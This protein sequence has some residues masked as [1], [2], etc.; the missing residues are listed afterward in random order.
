MRLW[1]LCVLGVV[2]TISANLA[3]AESVD[4][5]SGRVDSSLTVELQGN[6]TP[7]AR[8]ES[9]RGPVEASR[10]LHVTILFLP[11]AAQQQALSK[12][13]A[14][15]QN[16]KSAN[17]HKWLTSPEYGARFGL[18]L[19]DVQKISAWLVAQGFKVTYVAN[20]RDFLSF[21]GTAAQVAAVFKTEIHYF[22]VNGRRHF[23]NTTP[24]S[25]PAS[26]EGIVGG[27]RGL[28]DFF[29]RPMLKAHPDYTVSGVSGHFL[30]PGDIATIYDINPLYQASIDGTGENV[31]I[32]G[33]SDVYLAD[34]NYFRAAFNLTQLSGC[35][36]NSSGVI[37]AGAC[38]GGN[39][40]Q[41]WPNSADPGVQATS[42]DLGESDL[43]I[44]WMNA[45]ARGAQI[46]FV[47]SA[48]GV[49]DSAAWAIDQ[50]P[51]LAKVISYSY[52]LCE[53]FVQGP[54]PSTADL[55]YQ[56]AAGE[57]ISFFA[58]SGDAAAANCDGDDG[59]YPATL[60]LSVS[61][62][63]SSAY[64]TAVGGTEFDEGSGTYWNGSNGSDGG[65]AI[66][67]IP[68][69][70]WNDTALS[71]VDALDGSGGGASNC[72]FGTSTTSV[73]GPQGG[74]FAF[75]ICNAP[76]NGGF[77]KP[78][79][80]S[81]VTPSD[82]VRD[83]PDVAFSASNVNDPYIVCT[84][85]EEVVQGSSSSTSSCVS[86]IN[87]ALTTYNSAFGGTSAP[88]PVAA[89]MTVLLNQYLRQDGLGLINPQVYE[90]F[91]TAP[92]VFNVIQ[93]GT[94]STTGATSNNVVQC[95][96]G[97]PTFEPSA[98]QC[99]SGGTFGFTVSG[100]Q[101][102][103]QVTGLGS[104][105]VYNL[106]QAWAGAIGPDFTVSA[107][108]TTLSV[109]QGATSS[110]IT[111]TITPTDGFNS[112]VTFSCS[113]LPSGATCSAA[114]VTPNGTNAITTSLTVTTSATTPSG[115]S[116]VTVTATGP[117]T[118]H[119]TTFSLTVTAITITLTSN[120]GS[121]GQLQLTQGASG[122]VTFAIGPPSFLT[123]T[124]P[125]QQTSVPVTYTCA[126]P[127]ATGLT[128]TGPTSPTQQTSVSF[129]IQTTA[130]TAA[131]RP[132][133]PGTGVL[134][135]VLFPGLL[136][137]LFT[138]GS[139]RRALGGMRLILIALLGFSTLWLGSCSGSNSSSTGN[140]GTPPDKYRITV[141]ATTTSGPS[142]SATFTLNVVA[143]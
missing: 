118:S 73:T 100:G 98:L 132:F 24:P 131:V 138:V 50:N 117:S 84:P 70:G 67:Y 52:G 53:A 97:D 33:Q 143:Q 60:G 102:Y 104:V 49:D 27:L 79:W 14:D 87:T 11:S 63:A 124:A 123:G 12:L 89:G 5:I 86:G 17:Y 6:V 65:S 18:S 26:L 30:A 125:N 40:Q 68:E 141:N 55:V 19:A 1:A 109:G 64:V 13:L 62:P 74:P 15:Q 4:R 88:T 71:F 114:P 85:Q 59:Y 139:R 92:S 66:S 34:L 82:S 8:Q 51:P 91:G 23:A 90:F 54:D 140:S 122:Y 101:T 21:D 112:Q 113:G 96:V 3:L 69:I 72:A 16:R 133:G 103:N 120:L 110:P 77:P 130:P 7:L 9:D 135:A 37:Q 99:P 136:G 42:G 94:S 58:A 57:G 36:V 80:Q 83:V 61:Y 81:G 134:Y 32:A 25:I 45:V 105:D 95:E 20:G 129:T 115:T 107:S 47:T 48:N 44:E 31:V 39:F 10:V 75:E 35:P 127:E 43:D 46:I 106:A 111:L 29:P 22:E 137:I 78:S 56:K 93:S 121:S 142:G 41:V 38:T 108:P 2:S 126:A 76:P 128:C 116:T 119:T 28:H